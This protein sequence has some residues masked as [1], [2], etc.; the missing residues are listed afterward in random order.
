MIKGSSVPIVCQRLFLWTIPVEKSTYNSCTV[1]RTY[2]SGLCTD[3]K[4]R[5][6]GL[7]T[8]GRWPAFKR[9]F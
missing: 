6:E 9:N 4:S 3:K 2:P 5:P 8:I 7:C 1:M